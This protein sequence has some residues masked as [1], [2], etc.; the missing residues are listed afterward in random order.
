MSIGKTMAI[1]GIV[2]AVLLVALGGT[3][4]AS[5]QSTTPTPH[6]GCGGHAWNGEM[7]SIKA[8]AAAEIL[9]MTPEE[10]LAALD[11]GQS[12]AEIAEERGISLDVL[13]EAVHEAV[14]SARGGECGLH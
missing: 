4:T 14:G 9:G 10:V 6:E 2:A 13:R 3:Q 5:A 7:H 11:S 12:L 1:A 8:E